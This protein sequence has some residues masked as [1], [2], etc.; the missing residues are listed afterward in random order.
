MIALIHA[1]ISKENKSTSLSLNIYKA[2]SNTDD[3]LSQMS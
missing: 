3:D 1:G 2:Q